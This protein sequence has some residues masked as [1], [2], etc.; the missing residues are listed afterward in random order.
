M[1]DNQSNKEIYYEEVLTTAALALSNSKKTKGPASSSKSNRDNH[2][3]RSRLQHRYAHSDS[4]HV[5]NKLRSFSSNIKLDHH[6][7]AVTRTGTGTTRSSRSDGGSNSMWDR[8]LPTCHG[9]SQ[10][11]LVGQRN[12]DDLI[13]GQQRPDHVPQKF[14]NSNHHR[15]EL[16][17]NIHQMRRN[18]SIESGSCGGCTSSS[19]D[20]GSNS[21]N[22]DNEM[23]PNI[24]S[25]K[26][27]RRCDSMHQ[28]NHKD[29]MT[30]T[31]A[32][33]LASLPSRP[34]ANFP[35]ESDRK[36]VIGMLA[37]I[38]STMYQYEE[39]DCVMDYSPRTQ[40]Q[41]DE[42]DEEE[43]E[44]Q[45]AIVPPITGHDVPFHS[46]PGV[47][48]NDGSLT[49]NND[50]SFEDLWKQSHPGNTKS[51][52]S[53]AHVVTD[54]KSCRVIMMVTKVTIIVTSVTTI[55]CFPEAHHRHFI[56]SNHSCKIIKTNFGRKASLQRDT[57][58]AD[59]F[60][61]QIF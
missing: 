60:S 49:I 13:M 52:E 7:T 47:E 25:K 29:F 22:D 5:G 51:E 54:N 50:D 28:G 58:S 3:V 36:R 57:D 31:E 2:G 14:Q 20:V 30:P 19:N 18:S 4:Y 17:C 16:D 56:R 23:Q 40:Q 32:E 10:E 59:I 46:V 11:S 37:T 9:L 38:I 33:L 43:E 55:D 48:Y 41:E 35:S 45:P 15:G 24:S 61:I 53:Q 39:D 34:I 21:D 42:E 27:G 12:K 44:D 26:M 1:S 8:D 6:A